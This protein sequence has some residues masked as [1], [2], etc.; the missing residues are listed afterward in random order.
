MPPSN[1][2]ITILYE[3]SANPDNPE[4]EPGH[5]FA[6]YIE[7]GEK[8][9]LFDTVSVDYINDT[10]LV[11]DLQKKEEIIKSLELQISELE[12]LSQNHSD[13]VVITNVDTVF[14]ERKA[15]ESKFEYTLY[16]E[17]GQINPLKIESFENEVKKV[18]EK[19][20]IKYILLSGYTDSS[21]S[22]V[23]NSEIT[24]NRLAYVKSII[25]EYVDENIIFEQNFADKF[26][27]SEV[28]S[29]ERCVEVLIIY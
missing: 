8:R 13:T 27:S 14:A 26:A 9:I 6:A 24:Y 15:S 23:F 17:I 12:L 4:L 16:F 1:F 19:N 29:T 25:S 2:S 3:N 20:N 11:K 7:Y 5:G 22:T 18:L 10:N 21:G 28:V